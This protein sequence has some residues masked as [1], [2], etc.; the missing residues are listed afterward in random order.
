MQNLGVYLVI[1]LALM[2]G[3]AFCFAII[4]SDP[5]LWELMINDAYRDSIHV[6]LSLGRLDAITT[7]LA[8]ITIILSLIAAVGFNHVRVRSEQISRDTAIEV[9]T[10]LA[11]EE[12]RKIVLEEIRSISEE[13]RSNYR[14]LLRTIGEF[15]GIEALIEGVTEKPFEIGNKEI[16]DDKFKVNS[17]SIAVL[18]NDTEH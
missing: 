17:G 5:R 4:F 2:I 11:K 12:A 3:L 15:H 7:L 10:S 16:A 9:A 13:I 8:I 14:D 6:A 18:N 1:I